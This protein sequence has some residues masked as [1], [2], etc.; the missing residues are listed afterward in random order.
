[1]SEVLP[2]WPLPQRTRAICALVTRSVVVMVASVV[3][4]S[5]YLVRPVGV[6]IATHGCL[7]VSGGVGG[8]NRLQLCRQCVPLLQQHADSIGVACGDVVGNGHRLGVGPDMRDV[9]R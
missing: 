1:M 8:A 6:G 7:S 9:S 2:P 3:V 5:A 4:V